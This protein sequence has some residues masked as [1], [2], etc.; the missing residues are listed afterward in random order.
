MTVAAASLIVQCGNLGLLAVVLV[1]TL[2]KGFR[3][4]ERILPIVRDVG[5]ALLVWKEETGALRHAIERL[6][7]RSVCP[8]LSA[9]RAE[10]EGPTEPVP[11]TP[12]EGT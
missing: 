2:T 5:R 8:M 1:I 11:E 12:Q 3:L 6:E 9:I 4:A 10:R 7:G